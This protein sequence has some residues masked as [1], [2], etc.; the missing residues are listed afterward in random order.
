MFQKSLSVA[1]ATR[2]FRPTTRRTEREQL[3]LDLNPDRV[4]A[5]IRERGAQQPDASAHAGR[6]GVQVELPLRTGE[7]EPVAM[8]RL[9]LMALRQW[10]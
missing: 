4:L 8:T 3:L 2:L 7:P 5:A 9:H 10:R 1:H 6:F